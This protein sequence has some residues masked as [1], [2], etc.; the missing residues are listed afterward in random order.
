MKLIVT[1]RTEITD[2]E[3]AE[4]LVEAIRTALPIGLADA[5]SAIT[6]NTLD[7]TTAEPA[8]A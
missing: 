7:Q 5:L 8:G 3:H 1:I 6:I 4:T 2:K